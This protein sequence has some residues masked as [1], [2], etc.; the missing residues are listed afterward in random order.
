[1]YINFKRALTGRDGLFQLATSLLTIIII[2]LATRHR[3]R[4]SCAVH[5][6]VS[7]L[8]LTLILTLGQQLLLLIS[9]SVA[10][11]AL[12][13]GGRRHRLVAFSLCGAGVGAGDRWGGVGVA[14]RVKG[15][16]AT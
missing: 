3:A 2:H 6:V 11:G 16:V 14:L 4:V 13:I 9:I 7:S 5:R 1:M 8:G 15:A 12:L 10:V